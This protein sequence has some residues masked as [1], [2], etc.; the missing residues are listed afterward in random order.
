[1]S[2]QTIIWVQH[3][4]K[5]YQFVQYNLLDKSIPYEGVSLSSQVVGHVTVNPS[6]EPPKIFW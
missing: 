6:V 2:V 1:M 5:F 3:F 4:P